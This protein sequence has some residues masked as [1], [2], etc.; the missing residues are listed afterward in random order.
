M[1]TPSGHRK[2][3]SKFILVAFTQQRLSLFIADRPVLI[4]DRS[5]QKTTFSSLDSG[6]EVTLSCEFEGFPTPEIKFKKDNNEL[7]TSDVTNQPGFVSYKFRVRSQGDFGFYSCVATNSR[8]SETY[9]MELYERGKLNLDCL[10]A[11]F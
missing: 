7:N 2:N 1:L 6:E 8:G 11:F 3:F 10:F 5:S 4:R 9:Y